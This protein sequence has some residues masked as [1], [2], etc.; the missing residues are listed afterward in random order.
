MSIHSL[1]RILAGTCCT[2]FWFLAPFACPGAFGQEAISCLSSE[3]AY[4]RGQ[5]GRWVMGTATVEKAVVV[6]HGGFVL[7]GFKNRISGREMVPAGLALDELSEAV[8]GVR[9]EGPWKLELARVD[10]LNQGKLHLELTF[11]RG[12]IAVTKNYMIYPGT[13]VIREWM[14][15]KNTGEAP[16]RLIE[17]RFL[18]AAARLGAGPATLDFHWMTGAENQP[19]C[20]VLKTEHLAPQSPRRFD[21]YDP[22][23]AA[24]GRSPGGDGVDARITLNDKLVWP[25]HGWQHSRGRDDRVPFD[26]R[27]DVAR[28]DRIGF[29][30]NKHG[31]IAFDTTQFDPTVAYEGGKT[32]VASKEFSGQQGSSGW[33]YG[34]L[35]KGRWHDLTYSEDARAWRFKED[36]STHTPFVAAALQHPH[37]DQDAAR[38]LTAPQAG[39]VRITGT[40]CN[41]GN[42]GLSQPGGHRMASSSYAPWYALFDRQSR[43]GL[44]IGWDYMGHWASSFTIRSDG[45]VMT[46]LQVAGHKQLLQAGQSVTTPKSFVALYRDDLDN[47]GNELLDWQYRYLWD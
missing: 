23:P 29:L 47:A 1:S 5:N 44:I 35:E 9:G 14:T 41:V 18:N 40:V 16:L 12:Q 10:K 2:L 11:S 13:S 17:P 3:D 38:E 27:I 42:A 39:R 24:G 45:T 30:V 4:I 31:D 33:R 36:N 26:L 28:G 21:S 22:F 6:Q 19:G 7:G 25:A 15:I 43:D 34:Y 37:T 32:H 8:V 20:W 46:T